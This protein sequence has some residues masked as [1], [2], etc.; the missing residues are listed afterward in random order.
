MVVPGAAGAAR[1]AR[2]VEGWVGVEP[3]KAHTLAVCPR[4]ESGLAVNVP[5]RAEAGE[6]LRHGPP[7]RLCG[8]DQHTQERS[9]LGNLALRQRCHGAGG[10]GIWSVRTMGTGQVCLGLSAFVHGCQS[11]GPGVT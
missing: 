2:M 5:G 4:R 9:R 6:D 8:R 11:Q 3:K 7:C 1:G 10:I